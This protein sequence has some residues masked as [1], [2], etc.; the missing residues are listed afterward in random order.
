MTYSRGIPPA[1]P[2]EAAREGT[3]ELDDI[4]WW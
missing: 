3:A 4:H 1:R 2:W